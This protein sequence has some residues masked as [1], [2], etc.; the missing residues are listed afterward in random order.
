MFLWKIIYTIS[1][2]RFSIF[3][4][5]TDL[6]SFKHQ[7]D[8]EVTDCVKICTEAMEDFKV[9]IASIDV[10]NAA[11]AVD[12]K[13]TQLEIFQKMTVL[14]IRDPS[15]CVDLLS[16]D[17]ANTSV[18]MRVMAE[19]KEVQDF[20]KIDHIDSIR[21]EMNQEGDLEN[22]TSAVSMSDTRM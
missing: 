19:A 9:P 1:K 4:T 3:Y 12:T 22:A 20:V 18:V 17:L 7:T 8:A 14:L 16:K 21:L 6:G 11:K 13:V 2:G 15:H 10:D 5:W